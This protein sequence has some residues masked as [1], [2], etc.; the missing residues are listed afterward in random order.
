M[1]TDDAADIRFDAASENCIFYISPMYEFSHGL[2]EAV[3]L[4]ARKPKSLCRFYFCFIKDDSLKGIAARLALPKVPNAALIDVFRPFR[5]E[6]AFVA[7]RAWNVR[8]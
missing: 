8:A 3:F 1:R 5:H 7:L 4:F 2:R 6:Q